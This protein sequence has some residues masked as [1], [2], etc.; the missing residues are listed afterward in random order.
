MFCIQS[1]QAIQA[2]I[3]DIYLLYKAEMLAAV[4]AW[5]DAVS[6]W[7]DARLAQNES[8]VLWHLRVYF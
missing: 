8:Y 3:A 6:A 5:I 2:S 1:L 4:F 7:I